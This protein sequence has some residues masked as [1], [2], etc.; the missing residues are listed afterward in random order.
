DLGERDQATAVAAVDL[1]DRGK[2]RSERQADVLL[3]VAVVVGGDDA[4][5][6]GVLL[7]VKSPRGSAVA[8]RAA[9]RE[10]CRR[11]AIAAAIDGVGAAG[12][13]LGD[14]AACTGDLAGRDAAGFLQGK[15]RGDEAVGALESGAVIL[16]AS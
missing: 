11:R 3:A 8:L 16:F 7:I 6:V 1:H 4:V 15:D 2:I 10:E 5:P 13:V 14:E 12:F 9:E